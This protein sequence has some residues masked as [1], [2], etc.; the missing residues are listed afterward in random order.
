[1]HRRKLIAGIWSSIIGSTAGCGSSEYGVSSSNATPS[2]KTETRSKGERLEELNRYLKLP[3][4]LWNIVLLPIQKPSLVEYSIDLEE[5]EGYNDA[6]P[7]DF[8][9]LSEAEYRNWEKRKKFDAITD[10]SQEAIEK[11]QNFSVELSPGLYYII[12]GNN[13][14]DREGRVDFKASVYEYL[15]SRE[16]Y[17]CEIEESEVKIKNLR[18]APSGF[19]SELAYFIQYGSKEDYSYENYNMELNLTYPESSHS[20]IA[21]AEPLNCITNFVGGR[22]DFA[23]LAG[24][25][26]VEYEIKVQDIFSDTLAT[27][28]GELKINQ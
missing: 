2:T 12:V 4:D 18:L 3:T 6:G 16:P 13:K 21:S 10:G 8:I 26:L 23:S 14:S 9:L 15:N 5:Q 25:D 19:S 1:M 17:P 11:S 27:K 20:T 28:Q 24:V 22:F 7:F